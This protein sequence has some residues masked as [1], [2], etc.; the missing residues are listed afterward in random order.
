MSVKKMAMSEVKLKNSDSDR[1]ER[2]LGE[3]VLGE[4][5]G[6]TANSFWASGEAAVEGSD[7][8]ALIRGRR[9]GGENW[10]RRGRGGAEERPRRGSTREREQ[11]PRIVLTCRGR[12]ASWR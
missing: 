12:S 2:G 1:L 5:R 8:A 7:G 6:L 9:R 10:E 3:M 11:R 4:L